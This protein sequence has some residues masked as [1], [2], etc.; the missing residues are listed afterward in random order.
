[1]DKIRILPTTEAQKI[2]A[3]EVIERPAN[4]VKEL[5]ENSLDAGATTITIKVWDGGRQSLSVI[6][7]GCGMSPA[8][9]RLCIAPYATSKISRVDDLEHIR[10]FGFRGEALASI[11]AVS[12]MTLITKTSEDPLAT[13]VHVM[14]GAITHERLT[15][16]NE[17]TQIIIEDIFSTI[18]ARKKFL[19]SRETEWRAIYLLIQAL[20]LSHRHVE[21]ILIHDD[22]PIFTSKPTACL[23]QRVSELFDTGWAENSSVSHYNDEK[24]ALSVT[25]LSSNA[26]YH[27]YDRSYFFIF[28]NGRWVKNY[29]LSQ[30]IIRGYKDILPPQRFP[31]VALFITCNTNEVDINIH[32]RKEEVL[33]MHPRVVEQAIENWITQNLE[34]TVKNTLYKQAQ[35]ALFS[36]PPTV[37]SALF[38][39]TVPFVPEHI[40]MPASFSGEVALHERLQAPAG[41]HV[42]SAT[43]QQEQVVPASYHYIGQLH[44]TYLLL[45]QDEGLVLIDQHAAH[46]RIL[47]EEFGKKF[48][49]LETIELLFPPIISVN[50]DDHR[51]LQEN[52]AV[53]AHYGI[54][55]EEQAHHCWLI[56]AVPALIKQLAGEELVKSLLALIKE[57]RHRE[58]AALSQLLHDKIRAMMACK[59]AV[60][61]GDIISPTMAQELIHKLLRTPNCM[62]CPHGRPT[63][64]H[65]RQHEIE[66]IFKRVK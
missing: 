42:E 16:G 10:S 45:E 60:K 57:E 22:I 31:A 43:T 18:P 53:I 26:H 29:K 49:S 14:Q 27:R 47:Y 4:I 37:A 13:H 61:A 17:G 9:A 15:K 36:S 30:A 56:R 28:V 23:K 34:R 59:A 5:I 41:A 50:F 33:F 7:N 65:L 40:S 1:M 52:K 2:A 11:A 6:D 25:G 58:S 19:K 46:E 12:T 38:P 64:W 54:V 48:D 55:M 51:L 35:P 32:P 21:F 62:S 8:D 39:T 24:Y 44:Q 3:G 63:L 66:K 20:A